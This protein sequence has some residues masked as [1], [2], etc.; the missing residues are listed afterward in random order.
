MNRNEAMAE[1]VRIQGDLLGLGLGS[2]E[3]VLAS[4][5]PITDEDRKRITAAVEAISNACVEFCMACKPITGSIAQAYLHR[6]AEG[7]S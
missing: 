6:K 1:L 4:D 2:V 7:E 3:D 5:L